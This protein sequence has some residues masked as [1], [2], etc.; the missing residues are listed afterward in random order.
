MRYPL[1]LFLPPLADDKILFVGG[2][3]GLDR[4]RRESLGVAAFAAR[5]Q[6]VVLVVPGRDVLLTWVDPPAGAKKRQLEKAVPFLLEDDLLNGV[7]QLHFCLGKVGQDG[8]LPVAVVARKTMD[9][10]MAVVAE[11]GIQPHV[12]IC[13]TLLLPLT[14]GKWQIFMDDGVAWVRLGEHEGFMVERP[15]LEIFLS[16]AL[17]RPTPPERIRVLDFSREIPMEKFAS[18]DV[19]VDWVVGHRDRIVEMVGVGLGTEGLNLLQGVYKPVGLLGGGWK[20]MRWSLLLLF[21]WVLVRTVIGFVELGY[22]EKREV[23]LKN[24]AKTVLTD[25]FPDMRV[26]VNPKG[27]ML[28]RLEAIKARQGEGQKGGFV[29]WLTK[30][31]MAAKG[32]DGLL[33]NRVNYRDGTLGIVV[34]S[35]DMGRLDRMI[36][37]LT[38]HYGLRAVLRKAD[39]GADGV[40]GQIDIGV[41]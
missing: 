5:G 8:R 11:M 19:P 18:V 15:N 12:M 40:E 34:K 2:E 41:L 10:W 36:G 29:E 37:A 38:N 17:K 14:A 33:F 31:G 35:P 1:F 28:Q 39:R 20:Q 25:V 16:L 3:D 23:L 21:V 27:Q 32:E 22:L 4:V 7:E 6:Q 30:V 24:Q 9:A 26:V 13:D